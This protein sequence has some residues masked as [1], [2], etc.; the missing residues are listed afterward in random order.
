MIE[1]ALLVRFEGRARRG[2]GVAVV[3]AAVRAG[4]V[5]GFERRGQVLV[6]DL[7]GV[8][9]GVVDAD[10]LGR[11][12]VLDDLVFDALERQRAGGVEAE[13]LQIAGQHLHGG[14]AA[15][16]HRRDE[17][18]PRRE[19]K[20]TGAPQA[21][22]GGI[23]EVLYRRGAGRRDVEDARV[24]QVRF[25]GAARPGPAVTVSFRRVLP[26]R[27]RHWPWRGPRRTR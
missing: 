22:P 9:I 5:G 16:F 24:M 13:R 11:Q 15:P 20:I 17:I 1:E 2:L 7:K 6:D 26:C 21:E 14:D 12:L 25:A 27:R 23:G 8:G 10:L 4:D 19:R 18:G 3:G